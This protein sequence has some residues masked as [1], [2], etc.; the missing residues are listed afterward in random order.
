MTCEA[1]QDGTH[2]SCTEPQEA[3]QTRT[4]GAWTVVR[5]CCWTEEAAIGWE[6][7]WR[8]ELAPRPLRGAQ[9]RL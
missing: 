2:T 1:C 5:C 4:T 8:E 7:A 6:V 3:R 9:I